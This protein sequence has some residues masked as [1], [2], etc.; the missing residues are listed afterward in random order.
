MA[1]NSVPW[2]LSLLGSPTLSGGGGQLRLDGKPAA[3][4]TFL[5][6]E[7]PQPRRTCAA[8]LWPDAPP[9]T[10]RNSLVQLLRRL[11]QAAGRVLVSGQQILA[12]APDLTTDLQ[13]P[14]A[15][16]ESLLLADLDSEISPA[17]SDWLSAQRA[18][19][20]AA[21]AQASREVTEQLTA[22]GDPAAA[23]ALAAARV[24]RDPLDEDAHQ[25]LMRLHHRS[26]DRAAALQAYQRLRAIFALELG[27]EPSAETARLARLIDTE[28]APSAEQPA[29]PL[30]FLRPPQL[31]AR[32][33]AWA[34]MEA[35]WAAGVGVAL[36]GPSGSGKSRL[37]LDFIRA[38]PDHHLL[39]L[40]G[41]PGD[42]DV[43]YATHART[44]RQTLAAF[45]DLAATLPV[46]VRQELTRIIPELGDAPPPLTS[47]EDKLRFYDAKYEVLRRVAD[48]GPVVLLSDDLH[49]MDDASIEAGAYVYSKFWGDSRAALR[50]M[51]CYREGALSPATAALSRQMYDSGAVRPVQ[52]QPLADE[53]TL[54]FLAQVGLPAVPGL[55]REVQRFAAGNPQLTLELVKY[56]HE[57]QDF[58]LDGVRRAAGQ[59]LPALLTGRLERL[60]PEAL[61]AA[62]AAA[63]LRS[64]FSLEQ[65]ADM[66]GWPILRLLNSW[67]ELERAQVVRGESFA[68]DLVYNAVLSTTS[69]SS[70]QRL[71]RQA[72]GL[73][74]QSGGTPA[75]VARHWQEGAEP[76]QAAPWWVEA[77]HQAEATL[78][79]AEANECYARASAAYDAA[80]D[81]RASLYRGSVAP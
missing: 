4:L 38:H 16:G 51:F 63:V 60:S 28:P 1:S 7:G 59:T 73:L 19:R 11:H 40:Q 20:E 52:V 54:A 46:W 36:V 10:A 67:E 47:A 76:G 9:A 6:A 62:Q 22:Q 80:G 5:A 69:V 44:Y 55:A 18:E 81:A 48:R 72:A 12:L 49:F 39:L 35:G 58:S 32:E 27:L 37:A 25:Q 3:L 14:V 2:H 24:T 45:P 42:Q 21:Q 30:S 33:D 79:P 8:L 43:A 71:H 61:E 66:L 17:F 68:H 64:D 13:G 65:V 53:D 75:R 74:S 26:G 56:L 77:A 23:L 57:A 50:S 15:P 41:R 34:Q 78:H 70:W 31:V 29:L